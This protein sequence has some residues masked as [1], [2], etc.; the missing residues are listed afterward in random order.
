MVEVHEFGGDTIVSDILFDQL[1]FLVEHFAGCDSF[2]CSECGRYLA[3][4]EKLMKPFVEVEYR[5]FAVAQQRRRSRGA[6]E[7]AVAV[8]G[9]EQNVHQ[10]PI[11]TQ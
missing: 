5:Q 8:G 3:V 11:R 4:R 1:G 7:Q 10:V 6:G 9:I 2:G